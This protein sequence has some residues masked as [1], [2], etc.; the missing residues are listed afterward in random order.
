M[1]LYEYQQSRRIQA[2]MESDPSFYA[3]LMAAMR[4][5]DTNNME[6][7]REAFPL[8]ANE[9]QCRYEGPGGRIP[10]DPDYDEI[11]SARAAFHGEPGPGTAP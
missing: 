1:S 6:R 2:G 10:G 8:V 3:A 5:A 11:M 9:L 7:L 4:M